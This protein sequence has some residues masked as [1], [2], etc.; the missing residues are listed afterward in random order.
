M[1]LSLSEGNQVSEDAQSRK[2]VGQGR[3]LVFSGDVAMEMLMISWVP[4]M[5]HIL[6]HPGQRWDL[7]GPFYEIRTWNQK[8]GKSGNQENLER[9]ESKPNRGFWSEIQ[10]DWESSEI[11]CKFCVL[12]ADLCPEPTA[13]SLLSPALISLSLMWDPKQKRTIM[14]HYPQ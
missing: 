10:E 13:H 8:A 14:S 5:A 6:E 11:K 12:Q 2:R 9:S 3:R 4:T 7:E 1:T